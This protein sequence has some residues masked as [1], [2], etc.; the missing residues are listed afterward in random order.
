MPKFFVSYRRDKSA[1]ITGRIY[2][3]LVQALGAEQIFKDVDNIPLGS[4]FRRIIEEELAGCDALLVIIGPE[5]AGVKSANGRRR[6]TDPSDYVRIE[7]E[8]GLKRKNVRVIPVLVENTEMPSEKQLPASLRALCF[9][10]AAVVRNDPDFN[11]DVEGLITILKEHE[12]VESLFD[13]RRSPFAGRSGR[14][15][16][17]GAVA[18]IMAVVLSVFTFRNPSVDKPDPE[19]I[20]AENILK[21][22]ESGV[23]KHSDRDTVSAVNFSMDNS[24]LA[25]G[26]SDRRILLWDVATGSQ[27]RVVGY[28]RDG[29]TSL[30]FS[31]DGRHLMSGG[32]RGDV[33]LWDISTGGEPIYELDGGHGVTYFVAVSPDGKMGLSG[34]ESYAVLWDLETGKAIHRIDEAA[35]VGG[36]FRPDMTTA[37][38]A[39][40]SDTLALWDLSTGELVRKFDGAGKPGIDNAD[41][42]DIALAPD[43]ETVLGLWETGCVVKWNSTTGEE[44]PCWTHSSGVQLALNPVGGVMATAGR[45]G[46]SLTDVRTGTEIRRLTEYGEWSQGIAFSPDGRSIATG[47][48][49][50]VVRLWRVAEQE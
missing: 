39:Y 48:G 30:D 26:G 6:L 22:R 1:A 31:P 9:R 45:G 17:L 20:S 24:L 38:V 46:V 49:D 34:G 32:E 21:L 4:D 14:W 3:R 19:V 25:S 35:A 16:S 18:L 7:V 42:R 40:N 50:G 2:D 28:H 13:S 5:W 41:A 43:G 37:V 12:P 11:R 27:I 10:Q 47:G 44:N 15:W 8:E 36:V 23:L 33:R 29:V